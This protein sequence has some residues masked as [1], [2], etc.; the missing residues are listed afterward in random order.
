MIAVA[1]GAAVYFYASNQNQT[2][3]SANSLLIPNLSENL[4]S[5]T[6]FTVKN[7]SDS[8]LTSVSKSEKGWVVDN[9]AGYEANVKEVR[10]VFTTLSEAKLVEAKTSNPDNYPRLGVEDIN[11]SDAQ[12]VLVS[13]EG[14]PNPVAIIFGND[15]SSGKNTQFVRNE[16]EEKSWLI[17]K[18]INFGRDTTDWLQKNLLDI[19]PERI[20]T[21]QIRHPDGAI[22]NISNTGNA[23]YEFEL[24]ATAPEGK[25]ISESEIYQVANALSSLQLRD[26]ISL[27]TLNKDAIEPIVTIFKTFDGLTITTASHTSDVEP[28]FTIDVKFNSEDVDE[29]VANSNSEN[30]STS[31]STLLSDPTVAEEFANSSKSKL[32]GWG[33]FF[34]TI[35]KDALTKKLDD[36]F[37]DKDS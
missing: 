5:I 33:Y 11:A 29:S 14:L 12:G 13:I 4:N 32:T 20:N 6:K 8:L 9:R 23:A 21:I 10:D 35:T 18:K 27:D 37:I 25:K 7:A 34:P 16:R 22:I 3:V 31:N 28:F 26:V 30:E 15:G 17:N 36:F 19:P 1:V 24:D 2:S